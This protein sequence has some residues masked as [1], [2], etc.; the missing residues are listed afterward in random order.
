MALCFEPSHCYVEDAIMQVS[1]KEL[2]D[3]S[4]GVVELVEVVITLA[5]RWFCKSN[6]EVDGDSGL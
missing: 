1:L 2:H 3:G 6:V 4:R 5:F